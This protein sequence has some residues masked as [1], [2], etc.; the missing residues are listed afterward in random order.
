MSE[1]EV[2]SIKEFDSCEF[3]TKVFQ[4]ELISNV[5]SS[6]ISQVESVCSDE[7][8]PWKNSHFITECNEA[9]VTLKACRGKDEFFLSLENERYVEYI[10]CSRKVGN[11]NYVFQ[12]IQHES[13]KF[14]YFYAIHPKIV[15][16]NSIRITTL[17]NEFLPF[18]NIKKDNSYGG[19]PLLGEL[20]P[21]REEILH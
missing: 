21:Q 20:Y 9:G 1:L 18:K 3:G 16:E 10:S 5:Q 6:I 2:L 19:I 8:L 15:L 14:V 17:F 7:K 13:T 12:P 4:N 11:I